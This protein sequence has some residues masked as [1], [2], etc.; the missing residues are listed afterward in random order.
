MT[1]ER[2]VHTFG[3]LTCVTTMFAALI[4]GLQGCSERMQLDSN[5]NGKLA[6]SFQIEGPIQMQ[7]QGPTI[8]YEGTY[9]SDELLDIVKIG[10]TTDDWILAVMGEPDARTTLR[11]GTDIWRWT[12]K[13][14]EQQG[15]MVE[16]FTRTE[17]EPKLAARSVFVQLREGIA[18]EKW[19]G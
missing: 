3:R 16:V 10:T 5:L 4:T 12:Y 11:N 18:I 6:T 13:P 15:S 14:I 17:K 7:V 9:I 19:K 8:R 1:H 2:S